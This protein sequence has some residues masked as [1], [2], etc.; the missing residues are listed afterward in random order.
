MSL[1]ALPTELQRMVKEY[2]HNHPGF[3]L[4]PCR[5]LIVG[6]GE[7]QQ[8]SSGTEDLPGE[9][10]LVSLVI[11]ESILDATQVRVSSQ[12]LMAAVVP[13]DHS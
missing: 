11:T 1:D 8:I 13:L 2:E 6:A 7:H 4:E 5:C 9:D 3:R 10:D 12:I